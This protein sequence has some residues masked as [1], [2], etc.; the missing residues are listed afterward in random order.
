MKASLSM[1]I[2]NTWLKALALKVQATFGTQ[3]EAGLLL[4]HSKKVTGTADYLLSC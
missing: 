4:P 1:Y 3:E 2:P